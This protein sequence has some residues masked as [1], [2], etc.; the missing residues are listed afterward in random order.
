M[1]WGQMVEILGRLAALEK[2]VDGMKWGQVLELFSR[3]NAI[4][5][6]VEDLK[7]AIDHVMVIASRPEPPPR[8][9][10]GRPRKDAQDGGPRQTHS[11]NR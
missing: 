7:L 2:S 9:P 1:S 11:I 5:K 10:P 3:M 8:R 4:E 6:S